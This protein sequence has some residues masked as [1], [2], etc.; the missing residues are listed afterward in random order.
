MSS[1][2]TTPHDAFGEAWCRLAEDEASTLV[3]LLERGDLKVMVVVMAHDQVRSLGSVLHAVSDGTSVANANAF[4]GGLNVK[5]DWLTG[6]VACQNSRR[7][8]E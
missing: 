2:A 3:S 1:S 4:A 5:R 8:G 6:L 7:A